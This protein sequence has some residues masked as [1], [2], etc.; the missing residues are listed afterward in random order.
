M[1]KA[2]IIRRL[3]NTQLDDH[4]RESLSQLLHYMTVEGVNT[5]SSNIN[6]NTL[7]H[8]SSKR[9]SSSSSKHSSKKSTSSSSSSKGKRSSKRSR[10]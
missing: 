8:T 2:D 3:S 5:T 7:E 6:H 4:E 10:G 9:S 1:N